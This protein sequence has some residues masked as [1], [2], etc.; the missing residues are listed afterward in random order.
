MA[1]DLKL[2][3]PRENPEVFIAPV[4]VFGMLSGL[5]RKGMNVDGYL[6]QVGVDP[7]ALRTPGNQGVTSMQY[8]T[9]FYALMNDLKDECPGLFSRP[10]KLGSFALTA[11]EGL[12]AND[13]R[14]ALKRMSNAL[15][16]LQDLYVSDGLKSGRVMVKDEDVCLHC[17]LCAERCPTGAW[18]MRKSLIE[19]TH[20]GPDC[21]DPR[22][23]R[24][25]A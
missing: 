15:N 8:V 13:L 18:D 24:E 12:S 21:R 2:I 22:P 23:A 3:K 9:L 7:T 17:G 16:L 10:F 20:A 6:H 1:K 11:R 4:F 14:S 19:I 5:E 25:A